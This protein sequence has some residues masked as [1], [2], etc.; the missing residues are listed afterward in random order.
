MG[1]KTMKIIKM[2]FI[3]LFLLATF[4][5]SSL[6]QDRV[7]SSS[8][9]EAINGYDA[10]AYFLESKP[11]EGKKS[12]SHEWNGAKWKFSSQENLALFKEDPEK[13]APQ[14]G[15]FCAYA[16]AQGAFASTVPE[17]WSI[18]DGKLFLNYSVG[19][20]QRW[21]TNTSSYIQSGDKNWKSIWEQ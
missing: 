12:Y 9:A 16:M 5:Q 21:E 8:L 4:F 14:Y 20:R 7:Y 11:V 10:V 2:K 3:Y 6:A 1:M 13:Y 19:V 15:G 18:V 17:A